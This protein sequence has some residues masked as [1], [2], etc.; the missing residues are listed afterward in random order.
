MSAVISSHSSGMS[1]RSNNSVS[2]V[3]TLEVGVGSKEF[4][5]GAF[6]SR[7]I[8]GG[9]NWSFNSSNVSSSIDSILV[10]EFPVS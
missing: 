2:W 10:V 1:I 6:S 7:D 5:L 8:I 3:E 4:S 9:S